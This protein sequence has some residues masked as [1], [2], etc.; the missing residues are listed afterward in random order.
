[1]NLKISALKTFSKEAKRLN[2]KYRS[3]PNDLKVLKATL[4]ENPKAGVEISPN[5]YKLRLA[6]SSIKVGK[7]AGFRVVYYYITA[8]QH[9]YLMT[10][11]SK[12]EHGNI[13]DAVLIQLIN[14]AE[15]L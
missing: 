5:C 12:S 8:E 13:S 1:M 9:I 2:K 4:L 14:E 7:R 3:L 10:I 15:S 6:N 11:Y